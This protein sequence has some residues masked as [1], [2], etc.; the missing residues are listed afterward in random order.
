ME[1][2]RLIPKEEFFYELGLTVFQAQALEDILITLFATLHVSEE[3]AH[4]AIRNLMDIKYKQSLGKIIK[5]VSK[6]VVIPQE[7]L[8]ELEE[9]LEKRN[10][11]VHHFFREFGMAAL[12]LEAQDMAIVKLKECRELFDNLCAHVYEQVKV[13]ELDSGESEE[14]FN[15]D[16]ETICNEYIESIEDVKKS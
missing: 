15:K 5:D 16:L 2:N 14:S 9:A 12:S 11:V 1:D 6:K 10:W 13:R 8:A 4:E 3:T 7:I